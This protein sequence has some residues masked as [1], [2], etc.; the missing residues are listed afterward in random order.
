[1]IKKFIKKILVLGALII[2]TV[3]TVS[4]IRYGIW[5]ETIFLWQLILVSGIISVAQLLLDR[6]K[7]DYYIIEV[8]VEY[9]MVCLIVSVTGLIWGWFKM[10]YLWMV[11]LYVTPVYIIGFFLNMVRTKRDVDYINKKIEARM[12]R[13][14]KNE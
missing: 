2:L 14:I 12:K 8:L 4:S 7:C 5:S 1:M 9:L 13:G 3:Y 11:L 10:Y 6:Y